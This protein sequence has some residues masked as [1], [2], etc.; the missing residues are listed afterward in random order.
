MAGSVKRNFIW[1][2]SY[3]ALLIIVPLITVPYVSRVLGAT[4]VGVYSYTYSIAY[5]FVLFAT[6]GMGK[7][8]VRLIAQ[9][10][11][12][13]GE[14]S[15][16][17]WSA[18]AAQLCVALPVCTA[19]L[20]YAC[21]SPAG[22]VT[23][24][25]IWGLWVISSALDVSWLFFGVEE[26]RV[27]T[28]RNLATKVVSVAAIFLFCKTRDDLWAYVLGTSLAAFANVALVLPFVRRYVD[29][30]MPRWPDVRRHFIPNLRLFAP[31]VAVSLYMSFDK[32]LL[33]SISGMEQAGYFEYADKIV[34]MPLTVVTALCVVMLPHMTAR[35]AGDDREGAIKTLGT[36]LWLV[37][38]TAIGIAFGVAAI[39]PELVPVFLGPG[40]E[41]CVYVIPVVAA[42]LPIISGSNVLG[43]QYLLPTCSDRPYTRSVWAGAIVNLVLCLCILRPLGALGAAAA[44]IVTEAVVLA[45]Q[46]W[47]V[48]RDLPL[49]RFARE[50]AP[51]LLL[52]AA[53]LVIVRLAASALEG[54]L[55]VG[56]PL[57]VIEI[58]LTIVIYGGLALAWSYRCGKL[59][60]IL[61]LIKRR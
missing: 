9:A 6:L 11:D 31:I 57:L 14:R 43:E 8:G 22:G 60:L 37:L 33:G 54:V 50:V 23:I 48:R 5:Y 36:S 51:F 24:A 41:P 20:A 59:N 4:Q 38:A 30:S 40:Y 10:G 35:L 17:F 34:R 44:T 29:F 42:A 58:L 19:Y 1:N 56:W 47:V 15:R 53:M 28:M 26:F 52:G 27:P 7:Y 46:C 32:I 55:G 16:R 13:R 18:W 2:S 49:R 21:I 45:Y 61:S 3:Q 25:L 12:D 39:S